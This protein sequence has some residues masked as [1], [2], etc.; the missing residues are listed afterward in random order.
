MFCTTT[1]G[2]NDIVLLKFNSSGALLWTRQTG[3]TQS[4]NGNDV[5]VSGDGSI[6]VTGYTTG[7]LNGQVSAGEYHI[8]TFIDFTMCY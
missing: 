4:D 3:T 1:I 6:F 2:P 7:A 5:A 8:I